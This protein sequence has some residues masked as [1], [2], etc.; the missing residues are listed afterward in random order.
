MEGGGEGCKREGELWKREEKD[1]SGRGNYGSRSGERSKGSERGNDG[2]K[3][4]ETTPQY[5]YFY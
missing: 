3:C 1:V 2:S 4:H 5:L